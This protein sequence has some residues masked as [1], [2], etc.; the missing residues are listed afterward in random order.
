MTMTDTG[1][2]NLG[3]LKTQLL[4]SK[5]W[6][7]GLY[8]IHG[9]DVH[10]EKCNV[11]DRTTRLFRIIVIMTQEN[12]IHKKIP[13]ILDRKTSNSWLCIFNNYAGEC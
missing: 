2:S 6:W 1:K 3:V 4:T 9:H 8:W 10:I 5:G 13:L 11:G 7:C 12:V